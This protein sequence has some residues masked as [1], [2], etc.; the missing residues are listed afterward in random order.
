MQITRRHAL[1]LGLAALAAPALPRGLAAQGLAVAPVARGLDEPWGLA[2]LP[3]GGFLVT[4]RAGRLSLFDGPGAPARRIGGVP[5]AWVQGQ[6][7]LLDVMVPRDFAA[8]RLL[9]L[10]LALPGQG[11]ASTGLVRARL[12]D[13]GTQLTDAV[14]VH[15]GPAA[16]RGQHFGSRAVEAPDGHVFLT[17]GDRG[18]PALAQAP[19]RP[20][21]K[22][23]RFARDGTPAPA[24]A[25]AGGGAVPG[26]W[27]LGHRNI[28]GAALDGQGQLWTVEHGA[29]GGDEVNRIEPGRNYGWPVIS[30]GR[31]YNGSPIGVGTARD[32]LEQPA[33][34]WDPSIAPSGLVV[35]SGRG[36]PAWRGHFL[37]GS[38]N[39]D[40][41]ARLDPAAGWQETRIGSAETQRVR[42]VREAPDGSVWFL[43]V[44]RG[45][46]FRLAPA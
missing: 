24:P 44:G 45:A 43:S 42:D 38:L 33:H 15:S 31:N 28:Q 37:T 46:V 32:G 25:L 36:I 12:S 13:D 17:T 6:G 35:H 7:G 11:G 2:F 14:T 10:T 1:A 26:L 41:I 8:S 34:Y 40:H 39:A 9:W 3:G 30:Y 5:Q 29:R 19:A 23:L 20:E 16:G 27:S 22:V 18:Q 4:E 21:G